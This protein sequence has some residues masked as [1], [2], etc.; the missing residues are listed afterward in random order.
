M[1]AE[2]S[3]KN[4][5]I[6]KA[7]CA[8]GDWCATSAKSNGLRWVSESGA[9]RMDSPPL[10]TTTGEYSPAGSRMMISFFPFFNQHPGINKVC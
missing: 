6:L 9:K 1:V 8:E 2:D 7:I 5:S 3:A 4:A 10:A